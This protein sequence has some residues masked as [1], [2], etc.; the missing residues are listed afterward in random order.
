MKIKFQFTVLLISIFS[1][2]LLFSQDGL[3]PDFG[4]FNRY[5]QT[6]FSTPEVKAFE[7]V[8]L[9]PNDLSTGKMNL[10]IPIYT[11]KTGRLVYPI[12]LGYNSGGIKVDDQASEVGLGWNLSKTAVSRQIVDANDFDNVG[13][14]YLDPVG[15][16]FGGSLSDPEFH[17]HFEVHS[18][19]N[20]SRM[21]YFLKK[22]RNQKASAYDKV[23]DEMPDVYSL[24]SPDGF[25]T[26]F[27]FRDLQTPIELTEGSSIIQGEKIKRAFDNPEFQLSGLQPLYFPMYDFG[28]IE[29]TSKEGIKYTFEDYDV[30]ISNSF[31]THASLESANGMLSVPMVSSWHIST[32][33]DLLTG[34]K[35]EFEY[36]T[37][38]ADPVTEPMNVVST[39]S[40]PPDALLV[41]NSIKTMPE[42]I[43]IN[44]T[45]NNCPTRYYRFGGDYND[46]KMY[47][48][49]W[50]YTRYYIKNRLV[51]IKFNGGRIN[52]NWGANRLDQYNTKILNNI[53]VYSKDD[54][55]TLPNKLINKFDFSFDYFDSG[56]A[57][58][59][60]NKRLK[61]ESVKEMGKP[62]YEFLYFNE[63]SYFPEITNNKK[64]FLGY[65]NS[66]V[67]QAQDSHIVPNLYFYPNKQENS[68][69]PFDVSGTTNY[70]IHGD[71]DDVPSLSDVKRWTLE[72]I[73]YPTGAITDLEYELNEI[74]IFN[75]NVTTT[76]L[77]L[78]SSTITD[79]SNI[80]RSINYE[81]LND[82]G[83]SS[84]SLVNPPDYG[85]PTI[86]LGLGPDA[87]S[88]LS[89]W[90][91]EFLYDT[92]IINQYPK[93]DADLTKGN[94]VAYS[95]VKEE[96]TGNGYTIHKFISNETEPNEYNR[97]DPTQEPLNHFTGGDLCESNF[98][99]NNSAFGLDFYTDNSYKRGKLL[100]KKIYDTNSNI[101]QEVVNTYEENDSFESE[102][103]KKRFFRAKKNV[104]IIDNPNDCF[105]NM[106]DITKTY[107][108]N[109]YKLRNSK[110][111]NYLNGLVVDVSEDFQYNN[112]G[113]LASNIKHISQD[114]SYIGK[115]TYVVDSDIQQ[116]GIAQLN[117]INYLSNIVEE[118][119]LFST[120][121]YSISL[122]GFKKEF[123]NNGFVDKIYTSRKGNGFVEELDFELYNNRGKP[124]QFRDKSDKITSLFWSNDLLIGRA[125]NAAYNNIKNYIQTTYGYN[126]E[127]CESGNCAQY[128]SESLR[129]AFDEAQIYSYSYDSTLEGMISVTDPKNETVSYEYD[130]FNRL[131]HI[132]DHNGDLVFKYIYN[133]GLDQ[134]DEGG[135]GFPI[136]GAA[137]VPNSY[138][139]PIPPATGVSS[140]CYTGTMFT[141]AISINTTSP[142]PGSQIM[143]NGVPATSSEVFAQW[144]SG[145][146]G[147]I[148]WIRFFSDN[149]HT[150]WDVNPST[151]V[152]TG[153]SSYN[154]N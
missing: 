105:E 79:E 95:R 88:S 111:I 20:Q 149:N 103:F 31:E 7:K 94:Y 117:S 11:I 145:Y 101:L 1:V 115:Y 107:K 13:T 25:S 104:T 65:Y 102:S 69:L 139:A 70:P 15:G 131:E 41:S 45:F 141:K 5:T 42:R 90:E 147:G 127:N 154:C 85:R 129:L 106:I 135:D 140:I 87:N 72:S 150:I 92:F 12:S 86:I 116:N 6:N 67:T 19:P 37:Y 61:L 14:Q 82:D 27:Y 71:Y 112:I 143:I 122:D 35:I 33:E 32:I 29:V 3:G 55:Y 119:A 153:A 137:C 109:T 138:S 59:Y 152:I 9:I 49:R 133:Y 21:G 57:N 96:E 134:E 48:R 142:H 23:I 110:T 44:S 144:G 100:N 78:K 17:A 108:Q 146:S 53:S 120:P 118:E 121:N 22:A 126:I 62:S 113:L 75:Q 128:F 68:I 4:T 89:Q 97:S 43:W 151:G 26:K 123:N 2:N 132:K 38:N 51:N 39:T 73:R 148:R 63:D 34:D 54:G 60:K 93:V 10:K 46:N 99:I 83:S 36:E 76:G 84:G 74:N 8:S 28:K 52:F 91:Q 77:R 114:K 50:H 18:Y 24:I 58:S 66:A 98:A 16:G 64:D 81:Y 130:E 124:L 47:Y 30:S 80:V 56:G 40:P 136:Q 125:E